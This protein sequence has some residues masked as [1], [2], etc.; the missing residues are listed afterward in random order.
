MASKR[1]IKEFIGKLEISYEDNI[2]EY[3]EDLKESLCKKY[4][5]PCKY[6]NEEIW[7]NILFGL[8]ITCIQ[9]RYTLND[10]KFED[11]RVDIK[12]FDEYIKKNTEEK[13]DG[14][15]AAYLVD[16][17]SERYN[18]IISHN[19]FI[20][21]YKSFFDLICKNTIKWI[22][23]KG[24]EEEWQYE[25]LNTI[26][27][28]EAKK[29]AGYKDFET[30]EKLDKFKESREGFFIFLGYLWKIMLDICYENIKVESDIEG[31]MYLFDPINYIDESVTEYVCLC[32][33]E[34]KSIKHSIILP[35]AGGEFNAT[36][37]KIIERI[38]KMTAKPEKWFFKND[39]LKYG[40]NCYD[41]KTTDVCKTF[42]VADL[43]R[44][45]FYIECM[46]CIH[47]DEGEWDKQDKCS[48]C[49]FSEKCVKEERK[50]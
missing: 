18:Q 17:V 41:Y 19:N 39:S 24:D 23:D 32:F 43:G 15:I 48:D 9:R 16:C 45:T 44:D 14:I 30:T 33:K 35:G 21:L 12:E 34:D 46:S 49:I 6:N 13:T 10:S 31:N 8:A 4:P 37:R 42:T 25:L 29:I 7:Q 27:L 2:C 50:V 28:H 3:K 1:T 26:S 40:E 36:K 38:V 11:L 47:I 5:K 22:N 20:D